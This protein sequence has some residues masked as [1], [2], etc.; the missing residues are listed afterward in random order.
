V[1]NLDV[2]AL[3]EIERHFND[4]EGFEAQFVEP[5]TEGHGRRRCRPDMLGNQA[6]DFTFHRRHQRISGPGLNAIAH[7]TQHTGLEQNMLLSARTQ[8]S[9][10]SCSM[11]SVPLTG[12]HAAKSAPMPKV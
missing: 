9:H 1:R 7:P 5:R 2:D 6:N 4:I 8:S 11:Y 10:I 12:A 3:L